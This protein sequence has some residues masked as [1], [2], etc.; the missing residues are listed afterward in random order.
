MDLGLLM[1]TRLVRKSSSCSWLNTWAS[2]ATIMEISSIILPAAA[3]SP[4]PDQTIQGKTPEA[5]QCQC[6]HP[7]DI[8]GLSV[9]IQREKEEE[10]T[11]TQLPSKVCLAVHPQWKTRGGLLSMQEVYTINT[12]CILNSAHREIKVWKILFKLKKKKRKRSF[13]TRNILY[14]TPPKQKLIHVCHW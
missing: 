14:E 11:K 3:P 6:T 8:Q 7:P 2:Q 9:K 1:A 4:A 5:A 12:F 13:L 10:K